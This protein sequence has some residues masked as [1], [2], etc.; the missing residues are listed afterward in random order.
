MLPKIAADIFQ[1]YVSVIK[2]IDLIFQF[3]PLL[4][5]KSRKMSQSKL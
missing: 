4:A 3:N 2:N 5:N 1:N